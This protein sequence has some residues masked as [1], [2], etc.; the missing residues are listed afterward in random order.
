MKADRGIEYTIGE[1]M[2]GTKWVVRGKLGQG[3]MGLVLDVEKRNVIRG[4][5]KVLLPRFAGVP[6]FAARF[7]DEVE[8][9]AHLQHPNIVQVLDFDCLP[10]GTPF[11][12]MERLRGRTLG[13]A[14]REAR[15]RGKPWTAGNTFAVATD[16]AEGLYRAHSNDPSI[17]HRD[18][19][20]ENLYLHRPEDRREWCVKVM[21]FGVAALVGA[22]DATLIGTPRYMAPEQLERG[23][24]SPQTDQYAFALVVYEMLTGRMPWKAAPD[25]K[26]LAEVRQK[27]PPAPPSQFCRWLPEEIDRALLKALAR[28]PARRHESVHVLMFE[29]GALQWI[30]DHT[31]S[32][33]ENHSTVPMVGTLA[34]GRPLL[35]PGLDTVARM[36]VPPVEG[37]SLD[38]YDA[39][40]LLGTSEQPTQ[41]YQGRP[42]AVEGPPSEDAEPTRV[43]EAQPPTIPVFEDLEPEANG[44]AL[45]PPPLAPVSVEA[46]S[47]N[48]G[49]RTGMKRAASA[50]LATGAAAT[51]LG[52]LA[53]SVRSSGKAAEPAPSA[54]A[55]VEVKALPQPSPDEVSSPAA[56][57]PEWLEPAS[58]AAMA[59]AA[60]APRDAGAPVVRKPVAAASRLP[61]RAAVSTQVPDDGREWLYVPEPP[62]P[63]S[64]ASRTRARSAAAAA[65]VPDDG[66]DEL[67]LPG[68]R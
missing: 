3:G 8:V 57:V 50:L 5:M 65:P 68:G 51:A 11:M 60:S 48:G 4:A 12:V 36:S 47:A 13:A 2:P 42:T 46:A 10:D 15:Q 58:Q 64:A 26:V 49:S 38:V 37:V 20:P 23:R 35:L 63:V 30:A 40:S 55:V 39:G 22:R 41:Q 45:V 24:V 54:Q 9:T 25:A 28:D 66:R 29:L 52:I 34:E 62:K 56:Q 31:T 6:Q 14:M 7:L 18:I 61:A 17:V 27:V 53:F 67:I 32:S 16:V 1:P 33:G 21:D 43:A 59:R 19:K 44:V